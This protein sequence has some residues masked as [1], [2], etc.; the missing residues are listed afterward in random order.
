M[1]HNIRLERLYPYPPELVWSALTD[2]DVIARWLVSTNFH[3][4]IGTTFRFEAAENA[5]KNDYFDG[6]VTVVDE[7][8]QL[9]YELTS[10][11]LIQP[12]AVVWTLTPQ[13]GDTLLTLEHTGFD[14]MIAG[15]IGS[16][17]EFA[18][19]KLLLR[20]KETLSEVARE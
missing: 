13:N 2:P 10:R 1:E 19:Q 6:K 3:P 11:T 16:F 17:F 14:G 9:A 5:N 7:P 12:T 8:R 4:A 18:W 20:L 15:L